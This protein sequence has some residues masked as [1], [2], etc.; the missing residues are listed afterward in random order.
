MMVGARFA[1][2]RSGLC[3]GSIDV[4][5]SI[6]STLPKRKREIAR[7]IAARYSHGFTLGKT[8]SS[9][10]VERLSLRCGARYPSCDRLASPLETLSYS[11]YS[12]SCTAVF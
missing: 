3:D 8:G 4:M 5:R 7:L 11:R 6:L 1:G 9:C 10:P 12:R 2:A